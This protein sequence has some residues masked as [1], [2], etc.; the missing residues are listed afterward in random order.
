ME[1]LQKTTVRSLYNDDFKLLPANVEFLIVRPMVRDGKIRV[2]K[3][4][5]NTRFYY[6]MSF[7]KSISP[8][9]E[10]K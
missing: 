9:I 3:N 2:Q 5:N 10:L 4:A 7:Y 1:E 6:P 8:I